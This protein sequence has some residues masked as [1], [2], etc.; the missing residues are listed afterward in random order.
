MT[1]DVQEAHVCFVDI[2]GYSKRTIEKQTTD[3]QVLLGIVREVLSSIQ[4]NL[5]VSP[6][7]IPTGDG[8]AVCFWGEPE[9]PLVF[10]LEL[11]RLVGAT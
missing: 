3:L 5:T 9:P 2:V 7:Q 1:K 6:M 11:N 4:Q 8:V 10:A